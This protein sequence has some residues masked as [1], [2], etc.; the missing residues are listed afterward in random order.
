MTD[1]ILAKI[2]TDNDLTREKLL[3]LSAAHF[4]GNWET[5]DPAWHEARK[6]GITGSDISSIIGVN[7][8]K[9]AYALWAKKTDLIAD[10]FA[11]NEAM[12]WG[13]A[14]ERIILNRFAEEHPDYEIYYNVGTWCHPEFD[15]FLANPDAVYRKPDGSFGILEIKTAQFEDSFDLTNNVIP[16]HY[17]AQVLWYAGI[18][19]A[20]EY[21]LAALFHGNRYHEFPGVVNDFELDVYFSA[22]DSF[23]KLI[24]E[25][26]AP[27]F[28]G[29]KSTYEVVRKQHPLI[30]DSEVELGQLGLDYLEALEVF[31]LAEAKVTE[32]KTRILDVMGSAKKGMIDNVWKFTRSAKG[33]GLPY[34]TAKRK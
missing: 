25:V 10:D 17:L 14:A 4:V 33:Q 1:P 30:D 29:A 31:E 6:G 21:T 20:P 18:L 8:W 11:D 3:D 34:L 2:I 15:F 23:K 5:S 22:A 7:P 27:D 26:R 19:G 16:K 24:D 28:D 12:Y 9:S 32:L 13:R